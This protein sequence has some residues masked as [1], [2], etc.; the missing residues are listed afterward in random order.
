M[1][2]AP[3]PL[4]DIGAWRVR[5]R[6]LAAKTRWPLTGE[7]IAPRPADNP[8]TDFFY[9]RAEGRGVWKWEHYFD[10]YHRHFAKFRGLPVNVLEV[11]IFGGGSLEMWRDYFGPQATLFG[12]DI[13]PD[14]AHLK[15]GDATIFIGDQADRSFWRDF[16]SKA[17]A[18][19]VVIDDG[20]HQPEQQIVTLEELLPFLR[21]GGVYLCEDVHGA[22]NA[23]TAAVQ[24]MANALDDIS[25]WVENPDDASRSLVVG[26]NRLQSAIHSVCR[27]P[28]VTVIEKNDQPVAE[29]VARK[30]GTLW[31][32]AV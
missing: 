2:D 1:N 10:I 25:T 28:Y 13:Q 14:C 12:V 20:G 15:A 8:L 27:Y 5:G 17:P 21:P 31:D 11:G 9:A 3:T 32:P 24:S 18:L 7:P 6:A 16:R 4:D 30:R 22:N 23:F 19:D 26:A 29:L